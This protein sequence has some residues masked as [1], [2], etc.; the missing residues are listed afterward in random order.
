MGRGNEDRGPG[1]FKESPT[2]CG[3]KISSYPTSCEEPGKMLSFG[4]LKSEVLFSI[5]TLSVRYSQGMERKESTLIFRC[6]DWGEGLGGGGV[7]QRDRR[8]NR[9]DN[10]REGEEL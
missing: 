10:W 2:G 5:I 3:Q 1:Q 4:V 9:G 8:Y 7:I 6:L